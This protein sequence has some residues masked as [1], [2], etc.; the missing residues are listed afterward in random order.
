[1]LIRLNC[2]QVFYIKGSHTH[3]QKYIYSLKKYFFF[4]KN[5]LKHNEVLI[6]WI[7]PKSK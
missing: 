7:Y 3:T 6:I 2:H 5:I 1:M 4:D